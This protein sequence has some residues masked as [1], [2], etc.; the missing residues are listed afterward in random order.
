MGIST[1]DPRVFFPLVSLLRSKVYPETASRVFPTNLD[2]V[3]VFYKFQG[4]F[5]LFH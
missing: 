1:E 3:E 5:G 4:F 2:W